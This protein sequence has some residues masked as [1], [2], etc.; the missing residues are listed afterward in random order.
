MSESWWY[1]KI[2]GSWW[3]RSGMYV[4]KW[5]GKRMSIFCSKANR[6]DDGLAAAVKPSAAHVISTRWGLLVVRN[7]PRI[8]KRRMDPT[9]LR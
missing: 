7:T 6:Y 5:C 2:E 8:A 4:L 1:D 3:L 9:H